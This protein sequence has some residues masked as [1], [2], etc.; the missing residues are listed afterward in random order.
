MSDSINGLIKYCINL[1][2]KNQDFSIR[3]DKEGGFHK[4]RF[5]D[6]VDEWDFLSKD[7]EDFQYENREV[8]EQYVTYKHDGITYSTNSKDITTMLFKVYYGFRNEFPANYPKSYKTVRQR[9]QF[10]YVE[11]QQVHQ[12]ILSTEGVLKCFTDEYIQHS[13]PTIE[14]PNVYEVLPW[15]VGV[16]YPF[17]PM[18]ENSLI[19]VDVSLM[20][21]QRYK[22]IYWKVLDVWNRHLITKRLHTSYDVRIL[23]DKT[24]E[25]IDD[26]IKEL[27]EIKKKGLW[28]WVS[29]NN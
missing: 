23:E 28:K 22:N 3:L 19:G 8:D 18:E 7:I 27:E 1:E 24:D 14:N 2:N 16:F 21:D 17:D 20:F 29:P 5:T 12:L 26:K 25:D 10:D 9:L 15:I 11:N 13:I 6:Q 4:C